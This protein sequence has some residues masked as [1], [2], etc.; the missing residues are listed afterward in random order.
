LP[1]I[2]KRD[3]ARFFPQIPLA[4]RTSLE[5]FYEQ[6]IMQAIKALHAG[7][8]HSHLVRECWKMMEELYEEFQKFSKSE[9]LHFCKLG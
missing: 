5:V 2:R 4:Q 6:A 7:Q 3:I 9:V 1:A 8:L